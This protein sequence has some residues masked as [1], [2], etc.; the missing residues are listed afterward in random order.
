MYTEIVSGHMFEIDGHNIFI[1][2]ERADYPENDGI[3]FTVEQDLSIEDVPVSKLLQFVKIQV[4]RIAIMKA[5]DFEIG[6]KVDET[7]YWE[8]ESNP[9]D[10]VK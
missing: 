7:I 3:I 8:K 5:L 9:F 2:V 1:E 4:Y 10:A 6:A